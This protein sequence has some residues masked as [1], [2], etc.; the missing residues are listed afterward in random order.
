[1]FNNYFNHSIIPFLT[2]L[3]KLMEVRNNTK[4]TLCKIIEIKSLNNG[5]ANRPQS[6]IQKLIIHSL[7]VF[8][9]RV[10][11]VENWNIIFRFSDRILKC[12]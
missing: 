8:T 4:Y 11:E 12:S 5:S 3:P 7:V 1:M 10:L 9:N 6:I 2:K